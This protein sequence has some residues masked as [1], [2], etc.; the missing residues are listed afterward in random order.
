MTMVGRRPES[1]NSPCLGGGTQDKLGPCLPA[2]YC[3][4][5]AAHRDRMPRARNGLDRAAG[6]GAPTVL[7]L[8][9]PPSAYP[10][11]VSCPQALLGDLQP[12]SSA[13]R[14]V[15]KGYSQSLFGH[16][17]S[18]VLGQGS[19]ASVGHAPKQSLGAKCCA[20]GR[21]VAPVLATRAVPQ[22]ALGAQ[23]CPIALCNPLG[24]GYYPALGQREYAMEVATYPTGLAHRYRPVAR[25]LCLGLP[26]AQPASS[27]DQVSLLC[28]PG[29]LP[30]NTLLLVVR[31]NTLRPSATAYRSLPQ[32]WSCHKDLMHIRQLW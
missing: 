18:E 22:R 1:G 12:G 14:I 6:S 30:M 31:W 10:V 16:S 13:S 25:G 3:R 20:R 5:G 32:R 29:H 11:L 17:G 28:P 23:L 24:Q 9:N 4:S 21:R 2:H 26:C 7:D 8:C 15:R 27:R 19:R